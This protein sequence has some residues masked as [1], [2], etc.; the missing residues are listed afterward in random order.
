MLCLVGDSYQKPESTGLLFKW[1][2]VWAKLNSS[3]IQPA[4][5]V[6]AFLGM[7]GPKLLDINLCAILYL[8]HHYIKSFKNKRCVGAFQNKVYKIYYRMEGS[9]NF[10]TIKKDVFCLLVSSLTNKCFCF[11]NF[12]CSA[13]DSCS[14][15]KSLFKML[16]LASDEV[17]IYNRLDNVTE[18]MA[19][20]AKLIP[21]FGPL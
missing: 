19:L 14:Q 16:G 17:M 12:T 1:E 13:K 3:D 5:Q 7:R 20:P 11:L 6:T 18:W 8:G 21:S 2:N 9:T 15:I 4:Y 10:Q